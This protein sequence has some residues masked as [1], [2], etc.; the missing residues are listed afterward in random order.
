MEAYDAG[1]PDYADAFTIPAGAAGIHLY[2]A[3]SVVSDHHNHGHFAQQGTGTVSF[4]G[5]KGTGTRSLATMTATG[6]KPSLK[7]GSTSLDR[8]PGE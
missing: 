7:A 6:K 4:A 5:G 3:P 2:P 1:D 8:G